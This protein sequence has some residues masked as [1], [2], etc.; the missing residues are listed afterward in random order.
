MTTRGAHLHKKDTRICGVQTF[1]QNQSTVFVNDELWA[2]RDS[3]VFPEHQ[4]CEDGR[5]INTT[6]NSIRIED[7]PVIVHGPDHARCDIDL[8]DP[9][10][11]SGSGNVF[12]YR[13]G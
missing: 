10:T 12:G 6:G 4:G 9:M 3:I 13:I 1:V 2:V 7:K 8:P 5:L 11:A